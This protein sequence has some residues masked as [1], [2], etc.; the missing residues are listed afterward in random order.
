[1]LTLAALMLAASGCGTGGQTTL[2][3][4]EL[5]ARADAICKRAKAE[6]H[7]L[8]RLTR[9]EDYGAVLA[10]AGAMQQAAVAELEKLKPPSSL[11]KD[12]E[13]IVNVDRT[14]AG[15]TASFGRDVVSGDKRA[16]KALVR[17]AVLLDRSTTG[18]AKR[19]GLAACADI[20]AG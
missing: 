9:Y 4:D 12:W 16:A 19:D 10:R 3:S 1:M 2:T 20:T 5:V 14:L 18:V 17:T 6:R 7:T 8:P 15:Y 11:A 13:Q